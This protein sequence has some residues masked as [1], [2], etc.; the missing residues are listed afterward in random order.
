MRSR[1]KG[2][3]C[4]LLHPV[5][6]TE[7]PFLPMNFNHIIIVIFVC[8]QT[9][10]TVTIKRNDNAGGI[11]E[12]NHTG[13]IILQVCMVDL[14]RGISRGYCIDVGIKACSYQ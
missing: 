7:T 13:L 1:F 5:R 12:F 11:F 9:S 2:S 14:F 4:F 8:L 3:P 6:K 10:A